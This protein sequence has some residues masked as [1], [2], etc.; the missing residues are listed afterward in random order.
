MFRTSPLGE[1]P[2]TYGVFLEDQGEGPE[3]ETVGKIRPPLDASPL[4]RVMNA[5]GTPADPPGT[6]T[7]K[8]L[9][10]AVGAKLE[11]V[12][13][14]VLPV[15]GLLAAYDR[16]ALIRVAKSLDL[17]VTDDATEEG[18]AA[19]LS[20]LADD[21][22]AAVA[23]ALNAEDH[24]SGSSLAE[25]VLKSREVTSA[26]SKVRDL[27]R[28]AWD[29]RDAVDGAITA[30]DFHQ[31][32]AGMI[33]DLARGCGWDGTVTAEQLS[34][35]PLPSAA[36]DYLAALASEGF[37]SL[38]S[39][40]S[41]LGAA[42]V[43]WAEGEV[44]ASGVKPLA[45]RPGP[46]PLTADEL[47]GRFSGGTLEK[48]AERAGVTP[49][50]DEDPD[51]RAYE[52]AD[53]ISRVAAAGEPSQAFL[54]GCYV[55]AEIAQETVLERLRVRLTA[56]PREAVAEPGDIPA[57]LTDID[58]LNALPGSVLMAGVEAG[59][60][61]LRAGWGPSV[62]IS[63]RAAASKVR[64]GLNDAGEVVDADAHLAALA[65]RIA[66]HAKYEDDA[67]RTAMR[68]AMREK[69]AE[70]SAVTVAPPAAAPDAD[71]TPDPSLTRDTLR[72]AEAL[73]ALPPAAVKR[74]ALHFAAASKV[75]RLAANPRGLAE[76][77]ASKANS[78]VTSSARLESALASLREA[79]GVQAGEVPLEDRP[80]EGVVSRHKGDGGPNETLVILRVGG[81]Y[82]LAAP[83]PDAVDRGE[84]R[85]R[86]IATLPW[87]AGPGGVA[88][89][90]TLEAL[91]A[92]CVD[93]L[94]TFE[95]GPFP[96]EE[97]RFA[98]VRLIE[99]LQWLQTRTRD[100]KRRGVEGKAVA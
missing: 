31:F 11:A 84:V 23:E 9:G 24:T 27:M 28:E 79:V 91:I 44:A 92:V 93:K 65:G 70:L 57:D 3:G 16:D 61:A 35:H 78:P 12:S 64:D 51:R 18:L 82:T 46:M 42:V 8:A 32:P 40:L 56:A 49:G 100:R 38:L 7:V 19:W 86:L 48:I 36:S 95:A 29:D 69:A 15:A 43:K 13:G 72:D 98:R 90:V 62:R 74:A 6:Q 17:D 83:D 2:V 96:A 87:H 52:T 81:G 76:F 60:A 67:V 89:G 68:E 99:A 50:D 41:A 21:E 20:D 5:D 55:G 97:N 1:E 30:E 45:D 47:L 58:A 37:G 4:A 77:V 94:E 59:N 53:R 71:P 54:L 14:P 63:Q 73:A 39:V 66:S 75:E 22:P 80:A 85:G 25:S 34:H 88:S 33:E 26:S 10:E